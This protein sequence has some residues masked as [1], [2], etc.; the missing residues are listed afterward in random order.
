MDDAETGRSVRWQWLLLP[1]ILVLAG[2]ILWPNLL[3]VPLD[4][5]NLHIYEGFLTAEGRLPYRD[6]FN[7]IW[8]GTHVLVAT[9]VKAAGPSLFALRMTALGA[10]LLSGGL[11]LSMGRR[12][13]PMPWLVWLGLFLWFAHMPRNMQVQHHLFSAAMAMVAVYGLF[14]YLETPKRK[15]LVLAGVFTG[16]APCFTQSLGGLCGVSLL[17]FL[18]LYSRQTGRPG[19]KRI[20]VFFMLPAVLPLLAMAGFFAAQGALG[21]FWYATVLWLFDGGYRETT[22]TWY[23]GE[24][25]AKL[26]MLPPAQKVLYGLIG[27]LPV[28]GL[29][30]ATDCLIRYRRRMKVRHW[31]IA[32]L[33]ASG[34]GFFLSAFTY[35]NSMII[36][37]HGWVLYLLAAVF[38]FNWLR[39]WRKAMVAFFAVSAVL[40]LMLTWRQVERAIR[41]DASGRVLSF[42]TV[43]PVLY[44][45]AGT[46]PGLAKATSA[47]VAYIHQ[48]TA[49]GDR[50]FVYNLAP[51]YYILTDRHN[52]TRYQYL[53]SLYN[54]P[55]QISE[56]TED[57]IRAKPAFILYNHLDELYFRHDIRF[58]R[59]REHDFRLRKLEDFI[60]RH[61]HPVI[62]SAQLSLYERNGV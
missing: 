33:L 11:T 44:P 61:Y 54:T 42:G 57:V 34:L 12:F 25:F 36:T 23:F 16:L 41:M 35:P 13:L 30:W 27:F 24:G 8:P 48:E 39:C 28:A 10:L 46:P 47:L 32:L 1:A 26:W 45:A 43:E 6:F 49:P 19:L 56:A 5:E 50:I 60:R 21:E 31:Q 55:A 29:L 37:Y 2:F 40:G 17:A 15:W 22:D 59:F 9:V 4:D 58:S 53:L 7:F 52:P 14:R 18:L 51:E 38:L 3:R 20:S 62:D